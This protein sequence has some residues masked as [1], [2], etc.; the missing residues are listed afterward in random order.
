MAP[1]QHRSGRVRRRGVRAVDHVRGRPA[2]RGLRRGLFERASDAS[3]RASGLDRRRERVLRGDGAL[4]AHPRPAAPALDPAAAAQGVARLGRTGARPSRAP[5]APRRGGLAVPEWPD[6]HVLRARLAQ[7]LAG[8]TVS[9]VAVREPVV[10][11]AKAD[12]VALLTARRFAAV[13]HRGKFLVLT[14]DEQITLV[15][16][17]ML[18]GLLA[19]V[20]HDTKTKATTCVS[21]RSTT[22]ATCVTSTTRRWGRSTCCAARSRPPACPGSRIS[23]RMPAR[24]S[25]CR[26]SARAPRS[27]ARCRCGTS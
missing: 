7:E 12:P 20:P 13:V 23:G 5:L 6:L 8:R 18:S 25:A 9:T 10:L 15:V 17:P 14:F 11:R 21:P 22:A 16:N 1:A 27:A 24:P 26:R 19:L 3:R 4:T 2:A